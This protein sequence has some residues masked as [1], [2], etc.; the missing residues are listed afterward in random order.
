MSLVTLSYDGVLRGVA[1]YIT[2]LYNSNISHNFSRGHDAPTASETFHIIQKYLMSYPKATRSLAYL[3]LAFV[4]QYP[5][6]YAHH[7]EFTL[8]LLV[9]VL[10]I[11]CN[12]MLN[13]VNGWKALLEALTT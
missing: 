12:A 1:G 10:A 13:C 8:A 3:V 5:E 4:A 11:Y 2:M 9:E 7:T 6:S